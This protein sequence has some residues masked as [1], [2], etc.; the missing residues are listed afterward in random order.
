[1]YIGDVMFETRTEL[2]RQKTLTGEEWDD[3]E[4]YFAVDEWMKFI[5]QVKYERFSFCAGLLS[6]TG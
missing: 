4:F 5:P 3:D 2:E 1:M 6:I